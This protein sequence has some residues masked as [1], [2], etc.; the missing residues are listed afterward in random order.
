[1][2]YYLTPVRMAIQKMSINN[3][4]WRGCE[5]KGILLYCSWECKLIQPLWRFL[6]MLERK[7][8]YNPEI[9]LLVIYPEE[10]RIEK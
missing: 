6:K 5:E 4:Y 7:V 9:P 1:M 8:P 3:K 2:R 10:V